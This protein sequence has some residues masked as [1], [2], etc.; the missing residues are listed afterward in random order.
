MKVDFLDYYRENREERQLKMLRAGRRPA[1]QAAPPFTKESKSTPILT[2][3]IDAL[4]H[5]R[6]GCRARRYIRFA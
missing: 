3:L 1:G 5:I 6:R 4:R 2:L